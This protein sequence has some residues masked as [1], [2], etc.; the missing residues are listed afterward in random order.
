MGLDETSEKY[1]GKLLYV[2]PFY[3]WGWGESYWENGQLKNRGIEEP[4]PFRVR[5]T[6]LFSYQAVKR[7]ALARIEEKGY[8]YDGYWVVFSTRTVGVYSFEKL[9]YYNIDLHKEK[10]TKDK[11]GW[12]VQESVEKAAGSMGGFASII[13]MGYTGLGEDT[14]KYIGGLLDVKPMDEYFWTEMYSED[15]QLKKRYIDTPEPFKVRIT[16]LFAC[17]GIIRV[18]VG[19]VEGKD[20]PYDSYWVRLSVRT[21]EKYSFNRLESY[22]ATLDKKEPAKDDDVWP[23]PDDINNR[24]DFAGFAKAIAFK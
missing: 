7:G 4:P 9:G 24:V 22:R 21:I 5:V 19:R 13:A 8:P 11:D 14:E 2:S 18:V 6:R 1:V 10:P 23:L 20:S 16:R 12:P 15:G 3:G 17:Q